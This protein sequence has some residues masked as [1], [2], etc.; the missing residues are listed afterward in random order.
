MQFGAACWP[1]IGV[2]QGQPVEPDAHNREILD[3]AAKMGY[4]MSPVI[5]FED[6]VK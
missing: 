4:K 1:N 5:G 6:S 2:V 3:R